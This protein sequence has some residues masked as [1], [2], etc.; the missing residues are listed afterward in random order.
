MTTGVIKD[1]ITGKMLRITREEVVRQK[2]EHMLVEEYG[3]SKNQ[4][5]I[6]FKI[7]GV[8]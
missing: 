7:Q 3:Y 2:I 1:F 5:D 4:M 6:E 8:R